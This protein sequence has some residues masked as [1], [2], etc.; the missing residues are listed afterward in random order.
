MNVTMFFMAL[1]IGLQASLRAQNPPVDFIRNDIQKV[2]FADDLGQNI[3]LYSLYGIK[4]EK[5]LYHRIISQW[6]GLQN[7]K[8]RL[9]FYRKVI[10]NLI[11]QPEFA[12][13]DMLRV[14]IDS[15]KFNSKELTKIFAVLE[16][17]G[18]I[19]AFISEK[20]SNMRWLKYSANVH[21]SDRL[22]NKIKR[23]FRNVRHGGLAN[24][25][26]A[27]S[28]LGVLGEGISLSQNSAKV[29]ALF[30]LVK[31]FN[32]DL[33]LKRIKILRKLPIR[34]KAFIEAIHSEEKE[35]ND[36]DPN[37]WDSLVNAYRL[38]PGAF[39]DAGNSIAKISLALHQIFA[40]ASLSPWASSLIFTGEQAIVIK[41]H[42][43][44]LKVATV[45]ATIYKAVYKKKRSTTVTNMLLYCEYLFV[46]HARAAFDNFYVDVLQKI[47]PSYRSFVEYLIKN[48]DE[49]M[50]ELLQYFTREPSRKISS[51][52]TS[53]DLSPRMISETIEPDRAVYEWQCDVDGDGKPDYVSLTITKQAQLVLVTRLANSQQ[54][55]KQKIDISDHIDIKEFPVAEFKKNSIKF[56]N[57]EKGKFS[58]IDTEIIFKFVKSA[59]HNYRAILIE[60]VIVSGPG[61]GVAGP[62]YEGWSFIPFIRTKNKFNI[63]NRYT[64]GGVY[65]ERNTHDEKNGIIKI[66]DSLQWYSFISH[67]EVLGI[68]RAFIWDWN[69]MAPK[70]ISLKFYK[71]NYERKLKKLNEYLRYAYQNHLEKDILMIKEDIN[72]I[73]RIINGN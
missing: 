25:Q 40:T 49:F 56:L 6:N 19:G 57:N 20:A 30:V 26:K 59:P 14:L 9:K 17:S 3:S 10:L 63:S 4:K 53:Q 1:L 16:R 73:Q 18:E 31:A 64:L 41:D 62:E 21:L 29:Y 61:L 48:K 2:S 68:N 27:I 7:Y 66:Y 72:E 54:N 33:A 5:H 12:S 24:I 32:A 35:L 67:A 58:K 52:G 13:S 34:D 39:R 70:E 46:K 36:F 65:I 23:V 69:K 45:A 11:Y 37:F 38:N 28:A 50:T 60:H 47:S 22:L 44:H 71:N 55:V 8:S 51:T 42:W 43:D 15:G